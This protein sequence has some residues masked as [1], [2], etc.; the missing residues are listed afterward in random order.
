MEMEERHIKMI[1]QI[2]HVVVGNEEFKQ[3]GLIERVDIVEKKTDKHD[4]LF[5]IG[6]GLIG[7][8]VGLAA[9]WNNI[10]HIL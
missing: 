8:I 3:K 2:Y 4:L 5:K 10:K 6:A 7:L 9:F 1:E